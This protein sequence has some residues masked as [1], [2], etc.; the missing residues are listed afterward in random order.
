MTPF[1]YLIIGVFV[2]TFRRGIS[3]MILLLWRALR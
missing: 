2:L 3:M 1:D